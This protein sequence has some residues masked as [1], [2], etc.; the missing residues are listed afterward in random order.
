M[1]AMQASSSSG[2]NQVTMQLHPQEL[3]SLN[4]QITVAGTSSDGIPQV[5]AH[6]AAENTTVKQAIEA[7]L[8]DLQKALEAN[9]LHLQ[10]AVVSVQA[11]GAGGQSGAMGSGADPGNRHQ[12]MWDGTQNATGGGAGQGTGQGSFAGFAGNGA[13]NGNNGNARWSSQVLD[14]PAVA[15]A[16]TTAPVSAGRLDTRA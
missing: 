10:S 11:A 15:V 8:G 14:E 4:V 16:P 12:G 9:G 3:G 5:I 13:G 2:P 7:N 1:S 6:L